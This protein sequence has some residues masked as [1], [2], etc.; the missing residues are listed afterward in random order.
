MS[1]TA[2]L[3]GERQPTIFGELNVMPFP[4]LDAYFA[5]ERPHATFQPQ[6]DAAQA[7]H[8]ASQEGM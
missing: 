4:L 8:Q 1:L 5:E 6:V 2:R 3:N 7:R